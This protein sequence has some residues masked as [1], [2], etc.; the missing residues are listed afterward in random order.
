MGRRFLKGFEEGVEGGRREHV[1][2]VDDE[3]AIPAVDRRNLHLI[4]ERTDVVD[5]V[6]RCGI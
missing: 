2:L 6:V 4:G 1:N 5:R 3:H